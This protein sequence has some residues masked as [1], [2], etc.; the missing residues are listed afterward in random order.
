MSARA[1]RVIGTGEKASK[2][3]TGRAVKPAYRPARKRHQPNQRAGV[4]ARALNGRPAGAKRFAGFFGWAVR[5]FRPTYFQ[6]KNLQ[7]A[8]EC[9]IAVNMS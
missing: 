8:G 9:Q 3:H 2:S 7:N 6:P 5:Y 1:G 4:F